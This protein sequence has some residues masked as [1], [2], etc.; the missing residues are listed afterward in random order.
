MQQFRQPG[1]VRG[2]P[3]RLVAREDAHRS[4]RSRRVTV[5]QQ[6]GQAP[7]AA[8]RLA[9][10]ILTDT[11]IPVDCT[12]LP[13]VTGSPDRRADPILQPFDRPSRRLKDDDQRQ[14]CV[15]LAYDER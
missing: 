10:L 2:D 8:S 11:V 9:G 1:D 5:L 15:D 7:W 13:W 6:L 3:P 12:V 4:P 14:P